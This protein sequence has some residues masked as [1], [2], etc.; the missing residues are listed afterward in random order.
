MSSHFV[1]KKTDFFYK[2]FSDDN[3]NNIRTNSYLNIE[4]LLLETFAYRPSTKYCICPTVNLSLNT[5]DLC[6]FER[7]MN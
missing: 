2:I 5:N 4:E 6:V 1:K 7:K 3:S